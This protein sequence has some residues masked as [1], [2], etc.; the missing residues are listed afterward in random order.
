[1]SEKKLIHINPDLFRVSSGGRTKKKRDD[2]EKEIRV[3]KP[4]NTSIKKSITN[5]IRQRQEKL[6]KMKMENQDKDDKPKKEETSRD[7]FN[8]EF[9]ESLKYLTDMLKVAEDKKKEKQYIKNHTL[10]NHSPVINTALSEN[11]L[12]DF[13]EVSNA[14]VQQTSNNGESFTIIPKIPSYPLPVHGC[15]KGG[16]LPTYRQWQ[17]IQNPPKPTPLPHITNAQKTQEVNKQMIASK[18]MSENKDLK[19]QKIR[20]KKQR[21]I[22][23]RTFKLGRSKVHPKVSVLISNKTVRKNIST[24]SQLLQQIPIQDVKKFLVKKGMIKVGTVAPNDVL[25]KMYESAMLICG[26]IQNHNPENLL[27]NYLNNGEL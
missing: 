13:P 17:S 9:D 15:L 2:N 19:R 14:V 24:Q 12:L 21:R 16:K 4:K 5:L 8:S 26:E 11:V 18:L 22:A 3:R 7:T 27:Y 20:H 25:R 10:R 23:R 1:M 6:A